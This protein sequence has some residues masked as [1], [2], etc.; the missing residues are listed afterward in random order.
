MADSHES[1]GAI[2][3]SCR[4]RHGAIAFNNVIAPFFHL[5]ILQGKKEG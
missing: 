5:D 3:Y 1:D 4:R 2:V